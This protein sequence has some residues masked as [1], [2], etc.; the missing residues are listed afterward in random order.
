[1]KTSMQWNLSFRVITFRTAKSHSP[2]FP[3]PSLSDHNMNA[4][5]VEGNN[6]AGAHSAVSFTSQNTYIGLP[7][8]KAYNS[9]NLRFMFRTYER[10]GLLLYN[11]G[12]ASDFIAVELSQGKLHYTLNLGYGAMSIKVRLNYVGI[13]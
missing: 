2:L 9:I 8:M 7:Q 1:M 6:E 3:P 13:P 4:K 10:N 12:K 11:A 5:L